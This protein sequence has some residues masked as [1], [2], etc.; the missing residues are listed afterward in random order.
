MK[1]N[2]T[3]IKFWFGKYIK[4]DIYHTINW[5]HFQW[6]TTASASRWI[7]KQL[8][9]FFLISSTHRSFAYLLTAICYTRSYRHG[10][11]VE[12]YQ[13]LSGWKPPVRLWHSIIIR[14]YITSRCNWN[15]PKQKKMDRFEREKTQCCVRWLHTLCRFLWP[16]QHFRIGRAFSDKSFFIQQSNLCV[17]A[18]NLLT[19]LCSITDLCDALCHTFNYCFLKFQYWRTNLNIRFIKCLCK[20]CVR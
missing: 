10:T 19:C 7:K 9:H 4:H 3:Q 16:M 12:F 14:F 18:A 2:T 8:P 11:R 13:I 1:L 20:K 15:I 6:R 5:V 17:S